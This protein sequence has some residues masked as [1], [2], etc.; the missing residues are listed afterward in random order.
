MR[1]ELQEQLAKVAPN[2]HFGV[3]WTEDPS[4]RWDGDGPDPAEKGILPHDVDVSASIIM[5]G[6]LLTG[7]SHLGGCYDKPGELCPDVHG[8]MLS[9][10]LEELHVM[11]PPHYQIVCEIKEAQNFISKLMKEKSN[12]RNTKM[13]R[14]RSKH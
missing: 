6:E 13:R 7:E 1:K 4:Y 9:E 3:K 8:Y 10:A 2:I 12:N 5:N 11:V 14:R